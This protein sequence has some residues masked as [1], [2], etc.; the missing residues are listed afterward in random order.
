VISPSQGRYLHTEQ[1]KLRINA[2]R[3]CHALI[4]IRTHDPSIRASEDSSCLRPRG[5]YGRRRILF[6]NTKPLTLIRN[7]LESSAL[8]LLLTSRACPF[9]QCVTLG[10]GTGSF[11]NFKHQQLLSPIVLLC[12]L[13]Y[14]NSVSGE[15]GTNYITMCCILTF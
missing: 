13:N 7:H 5:H 4:G 10:G 15:L 2:H 8:E 11:L 14:T 9:T 6:I 3:D 1:H 12:L